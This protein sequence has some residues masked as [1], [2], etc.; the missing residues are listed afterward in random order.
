[1]R[2]CNPEPFS[3]FSQTSKTNPPLQTAKEDATT[4]FHTPVASLR[5]KTKQYPNRTNADKKQRLMTSN[6]SINF[7]LPNKKR[8]TTLQPIRT[9]STKNKRR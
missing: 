6:F 2:R 7:Q 3:V 4:T 5:Q 1:L 8:R 9:C